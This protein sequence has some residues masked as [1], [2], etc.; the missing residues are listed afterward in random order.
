MD[1]S[2]F[3]NY[4]EGAY[5]VLFNKILPPQKYIYFSSMRLG[6]LQNADNMIETYEC[7]LVT[8]NFR[9]EQKIED[10]DINQ[11]WNVLLYKHCLEHY[12][13]ILYRFILLKHI[14]LP[15]YT[16][17]MEVS[18]KPNCFYVD[19]NKNTNM[20]VLDYENNIKCEMLRGILK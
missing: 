3:D 15:I 14:T 9:L 4:R 13:C 11:I 18:N 17:S 8:T 1:I 5:A 19:F 16:I 12:F 20:P 10:I 2:L 6:F 7:Q